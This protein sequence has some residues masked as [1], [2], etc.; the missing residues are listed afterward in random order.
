MGSRSGDSCG[1][2]SADD[3]DD[4]SLEFDEG[5]LNGCLAEFEEDRVA[6][7][8]Q[9]KALEEK[10]FKLDGG[11]PACNAE[12]IKHNGV[13]NASWGKRN[14]SIG[15]KK[16]PLF[17]A[18]NLENDD[19][20]STKHDV[21]DQVLPESVSTLAVDHEKLAIAQMLDQIYLRLQAFEADRDFLKNCLSSLKRGGKGLNLL[22]EIVH[23]IQDLRRGEISTR[24]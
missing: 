15:G 18:A 5:G 24:V 3:C 12:S 22:Q 10:L 6:M 7:L 16:L 21:V 17:D 23:H 20:I 13:D 2:S 9:L 4:L 11:G 14:C 8:E 1:S 19:E